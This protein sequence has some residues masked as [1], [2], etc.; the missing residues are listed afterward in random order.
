MSQR[1]VP[2]NLRAVSMESDFEAVSPCGLSR[3]PGMRRNLLPLLL[4][5]WTSLV[6]SKAGQ[7]GPNHLSGQTAPYLKRAISQPVDWYPWGADAFKRA[8]ELNRPILLDMGAVWCGWCDLMDRESYF[9]P[10]LAAFI[11]AN[12]VAVKV[13][14]D[15][16]PQLAAELER[17]Q[18][19]LNLPSG[20]PLTGFLIPTGKLYFGGT[21]FPREAKGDKPAFEDVLKQALRM[22]RQHRTEVG[23]DGV[24]LIKEK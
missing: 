23:R 3:L 11:N 21:Y 14:Y 12:F 15:A 6:V 20:L 9:R 5:T 7:A 8:R 1:E 2:V 17:A 4:L 19:V 10:E 24:D 18:A 22:I 13:D 16:Q